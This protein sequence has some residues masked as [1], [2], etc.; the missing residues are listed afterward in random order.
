MVQELGAQNFL[1]F[2]SL[3]YLTYVTPNFNNRKHPILNLL[4]FKKYL[5]KHIIN[6]WLAI[7]YWHIHAYNTFFFLSF[8]IFLGLWQKPRKTKIVAKSLYL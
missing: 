1:I 7:K 6:E 5:K 2:Y 8:V 3:D 4:H